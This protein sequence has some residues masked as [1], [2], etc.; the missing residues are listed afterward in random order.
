[1]YFNWD[2]KIITEVSKVIIQ[3]AKKQTDCFISSTLNTKLPR[4]CVV[5]LK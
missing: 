5:I 4:H 2:F 3:P 1:M